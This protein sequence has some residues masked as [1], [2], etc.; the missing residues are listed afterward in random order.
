[1]TRSSISATAEF[2]TAE[3]LEIQAFLG[4]KLIIHV[5]P[6]TEVTNKWSYT[7]TSRYAFMAIAQQT[8]PCTGFIKFKTKALAS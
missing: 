4:F 8:V 5:Y 3:W 2:L 6:V 7:F 1:V